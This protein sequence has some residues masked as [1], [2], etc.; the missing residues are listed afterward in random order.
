MKTYKTESNEEWLYFDEWLIDN[1]YYKWEKQ[2]DI[3]A[4]TGTDEE[5]I[6]TIKEDLL[7]QFYA[8]CD[9]NGYVGQ[10]V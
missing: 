8:F 10:E 5:E 3:L 2:Y 1:C 4:S 6:D 7:N 9:E